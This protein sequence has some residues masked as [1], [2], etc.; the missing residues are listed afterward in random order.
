MRNPV[1]S[2][3]VA[4]LVSVLCE[5]ALPAT[6]WAQAQAPQADTRLGRALDRAVLR[7]QSRSDLRDFRGAGFNRDSF[8]LEAFKGLG[9]AEDSTIVGW[10]TGFNEFIGGVDSTACGNLTRNDPTGTLLAT[11]PSSMDSAGVER[12]VVHWET[13]VAASFLASEPPPANEEEMMVAMFALIAKLPDTE[14]S[15]STRLSDKP[16]KPN[17][18]RECRMMRGF[19]A[20]ALVLEEPTRMTLLRGIASMLDGKKSKSTD[21]KQ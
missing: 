12:W 19:L 1:R 7:V 5:T 4:T 6:G 20:E 14:V 16:T 18:Q 3:L 2:L 17:P 9:K 10:F 13:A 8:N 21:V 11:I 15:V